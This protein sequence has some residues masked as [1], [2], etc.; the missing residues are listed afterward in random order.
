MVNLAISDERLTSL[1]RFLRRTT[2]SVFICYYSHVFHTDTKGEIYLTYVETHFSFV[3]YIKNYFRILF[4][5]CIWTYSTYLSCLASRR[6]YRIS[7]PRCNCSIVFMPVKSWIFLR[8]LNIS[9]QETLSILLR[10]SHNS[11]D[12]SLTIVASFSFQASRP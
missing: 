3:R 9:I 5:V 10:R 8:L 12:C 6:Q 7:P 2:F 11:I 4:T 1:F